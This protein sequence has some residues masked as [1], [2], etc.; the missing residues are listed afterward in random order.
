MSGTSA[1]LAPELR[2]LEERFT[3]ARIGVALQSGTVSL[4]RPRSAED[5]LSEADFARDE[6]LPYWAELWPSAEV[7]AR[8]VTDLGP[9]SGRA[10]EFGCG[11]G[12]VSIAALHAG[13][14]VLATDYY[15][16][17]LLFTR[18]NAL[19]AVGREP[20]TLLLDW[21]RLPDDLGRFDLVLASDVLYERPYAEL[22]ARAVLSTLAPGGLVLL[23]DPGRSAL[24]Q[25]AEA[26]AH[27]GGVV[28]ERSRTPWEEGTIHQTIRILEIRADT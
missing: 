7:L 14:D 11:L 9:A 17:A 23:A 13:F 12:L 26:C 19:A 10:I 8:V 24:A 16:D 28:R 18:R 22:V 21:R 15:A 5:L 1:A 6:R 27:S 4:E 2:A 25:F 3:L 20:R